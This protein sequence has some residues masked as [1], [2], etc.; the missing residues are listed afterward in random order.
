MVVPHPAEDELL[1]GTWGSRH[2]Y[3]T[4]L[5]GNIKSKRPNPCSDEM[6]HQDA[7]LMSGRMGTLNNIKLDPTK[8]QWI[9]VRER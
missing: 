2:Y 1:L 9:E 8:P 4:D 3:R 7:Q 6:E 5:K